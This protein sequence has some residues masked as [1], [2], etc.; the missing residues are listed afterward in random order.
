[1]LVLNN[2]SKGFG[3]N[4]KVLEDVSIELNHGMA[5]IVS[6]R[7]G[8]GKTT[9]ARII[10]GVYLADT[11][12]IF[13]N[14]RKIVMTSPA[15][16]RYMMQETGFAFSDEKSFYGHLT[17]EENI[18]FFRSIYGKEK[19][20][21]YFKALSILGMEKFMASR[22]DS[23]SKGTKQKLCFLRALPGRPSLLVIDE[24]DA[25]DDGSLEGADE[26]LSGFV[27]EGGAVLKFT[28]KNPDK[29][30]ARRKF[31]SVNFFAL[32][33]GRLSHIDL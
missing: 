8:S 9:M 30:A 24:L 18:D 15:D 33:G 29:V 5:A 14:G 32:E 21:L 7:N 22:F 19:N 23:L 20:P 1:M 26:I 31:P 28:S 3:V 2:I 13:F 12:D 10:A 4:R 16:K 27:N 17:A 11:G 6:G 25:M